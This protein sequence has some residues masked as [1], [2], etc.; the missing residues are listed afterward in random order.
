MAPDNFHCAFHPLHE[1]LLLR[2]WVETAIC[3]FF[4]HL[5]SCRLALLLARKFTYCPNFSYLGLEKLVLV[6]I[7]FF[8]ISYYFCCHLALR[9]RWVLARLGGLPFEFFQ[10]SRFYLNN[11]LGLCHIFN[12]WNLAIITLYHRRHIDV[13]RWRD[14][15]G[16]VDLFGWCNGLGLHNFATRAELH[17]SYGEGN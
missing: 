3:R 8:V 4:V 16:L 1:V 2:F 7:D 13:A 10:R 14:H 17:L 12:V 15:W 6:F 9:V 5:K 11:T